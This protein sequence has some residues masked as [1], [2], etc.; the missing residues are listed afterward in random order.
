MCVGG[1][2]RA[3]EDPNPPA[4]MLTHL[5]SGA[6]GPPAAADVPEMAEPSRRVHTVGVPGPA[7]PALCRAHTGVFSTRG[8]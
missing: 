4:P 3:A 5:G 2:L 7:G 8:I 1:S 6:N